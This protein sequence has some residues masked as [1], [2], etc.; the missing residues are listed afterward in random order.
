MQ[1]VQPLQYREPA[2]K[3]AP[4]YSAPQIPHINSFGA[5]L[6]YVREREQLQQREV[7]ETFPEI[8]EQY[9]VPHLT[10]DMYRKME[11]GKRAPQYEELL[12]L[13][14]SLTTGNGILF[15]P[16]ERRM[17]VGLSR[18][19]IES[20]QS[21]RPKFRSNSEWR[22]LELQLAQI[23]HDTKS[24]EALR[25]NEQGNVRRVR[26]KLVLDTSHIVGRQDWLIKMLSYLNTSLSKKI[27]VIQGIMGVGK[28]S[29][30]KLLLQNLLEHEEY[31]PILYTFSPAM[32]MT[33]DDHL[34]TFL[35]TILAELGVTV[36]EATKM[37]LAERIEQVLEQITTI[38]QRVI[39][40][41]DDAQAI[42]DRQ[43]QLT[44][45]WCQFFTAYLQH[46]HQA[47]IY[48]ATREWPLWTER[49]RS[50]LVD[51]DETMMP[52][53]SPEAGAEIW[54]HLGFT[55]VPNYLLEQATGRC[56]GNALMIELR[57]ASLQR[58]KLFFSWHKH[59][60]L[61]P[62][63]EK[64]SERIQRIEQLLS[65][66]HV[67]GTADVEA[68]E[69]LKQVVSRWLSYDALQLLEILAVSP[70]PLPFPLLKEIKSQQAE[71]SVVELLKASLLDQDA[72]NLNERSQLQPLVREAVVQKLLEEGRIA[73]IERQLTR[74]YR[75][76]L[77]EGTF[78][79]DQEQAVLIT[80]TALLYLKEYLLLEAAELL[81]NVGWI[82]FAFG[83]GPRLARAMEETVT[84][85]DWPYSNK[86]NEIGKNLLHYHL[87]RFLGKEV[88]IEERAKAYSYIYSIATFH[89]IE[90]LPTTE[91]HLIQHLVIHLAHDAHFAEAQALV[92]DRLVRIQPL[93]EADPLTF[94]S[95][96]YYQA[97]LL[98]K[99]SEHEEL[100]GNRELSRSYLQE[101]VEMYSQC[102]EL[103]KES[104]RE[105]SS[106]KRRTI[107]FKLARR[108]TDF[109]YYAGKLGLS[110]DTIQQA[111][112][113]SIKLKKCGYA[114]PGS[115][116]MAYGEYAQ[117]LA[118]R[119]QFQKAFSYSDL[120]LQ[121]VENL[122]D[123]HH[124]SALRERAVLQIDRG[125]LLL[126]LGN[127][128]EAQRLFEDA[129]KY[130]RDT[131][132]KMYYTKAEQGLQAIES[133]RSVSPTRK[134]DWRW[135]S[136]YE[137]IADYD[138]HFW[139]NPAGTFT[140]E[141]QH[142][143]DT[144][145]GKSDD[146]AITRM[147]ELMATSRE[148]ELLLCI[149][150]QRNPSLLYPAIPIDKVRL[151]ISESIQLRNDIEHEEKN[152][153]VKNLY[154]TT[155]DEQLDTLYM[156]EATYTGDAHS[157]CM[158]NR[159]LN[160]EPS[161]RE[162]DIAANELIRVLIRGMGQEETASI[163]V[164][165]FH[166]LQVLKLISPY[167]DLEDEYRREQMQPSENLTVSTAQNQEVFS[168]ETV[169]SFFKS[170][171]HEYQFENWDVVIDPA[172]T[173]ARV[174]PQTRAIFLPHRP[175]SLEKVIHLLSHEIESH[176]FRFAA[177]TKSSLAL[178]GFGTGGYLP[179]EEALANYYDKL[180]TIAQADVTQTEIPWIGTIATGLASGAN[181]LAGGSVPAH[182]FYELFS[183]F[184]QYHLLNRLL[185]GKD[186][187]YKI[188]Q[189]EARR[190]AL[191]RCVRTWRGAPAPLVRGV[192]STK[193]NS[194]L[195]G[196]LALQQA[197][198][199]NGLDIVDHLMVGAISLDQLDACAELGIVAPAIQHKRLA[200]DPNIRQRIA[201]FKK[202]S[203]K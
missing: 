131:T 49:N 45:N 186:K 23:D 124:P 117:F 178:L 52:S 51:G 109:G 203:L 181:C 179:T 167:R 5:F 79:N 72:M 2:L 146:G 183:F 67:F 91:I 170:V 32:N 139:L 10:A 190:L 138:T 162:M 93:R 11:Q 130:V 129:K 28:T 187:E 100:Q 59:P 64:K 182:S 133:W 128:D 198:Q 96:L 17:Y 115:L 195:H 142:E 60:V 101:A 88:S 94:S 120:A 157:F 148:R 84:F 43:G 95:F 154:L 147:S 7:S 172:A 50:F 25:E 44:A 161:A 57:A 164:S 127:L 158:Y 76:W 134:L 141:E 90:L 144:L 3:G 87:T 38:E 140:Q 171:L 54:R 12:P 143:W 35:A 63:Q 99:W 56:G 111:L 192:C 155:L 103:L 121:E 196:Y 48:L 69:L 201:S 4:L 97:Y 80:E 65:E 159:K 61:S 175:M 118:T 74:M 193:D 33:P 82:S 110:S 92:T 106:I 37:S 77:D 78:Q 137:R 174:E 16:E 34:D 108:L 200:H 168:S 102:I 114:L 165:L 160:P 89:D 19:K 149:E 36:P 107:E 1:H 30:I 145:T 14:V 136:R 151:K 13:Y 191:N 169:K 185:A 98:A 166:H 31:W 9:H 126:L 6:R 55:D 116:A 27:V 125:H 46:Q 119:G 197:L 163:C 26:Q 24:E 83:H 21:R 202:E 152:I 68:K 8:F 73:D 194:Y 18:L 199:E 41:V 113:E 86:K 53:L 62:K 75:V 132:R 71:Y 15:S 150:E 156:I 58:P 42:L 112:E 184:E 180:T 177:G 189:R 123:V 176:T 39:L 105:A 29:G 153:V 188:A 85:S 47:L 40:L 173:N 66:V 70:I 122:V 104:K 20:L 22:F 81:I 135:F